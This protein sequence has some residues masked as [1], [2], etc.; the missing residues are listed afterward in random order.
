MRVIFVPCSRRAPG[1]LHAWLG[2]AA[3]VVTLLYVHLATDIHGL[4]YAPIGV[5]TCFVV[6]WAAS[7]L[8]APR[9]ASS[10][11]EASSLK[12]QA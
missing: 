7:Y 3:S 2:A 6:A 8:I 4:M 5:T 12:P 9:R 10:A 1:P 11:P